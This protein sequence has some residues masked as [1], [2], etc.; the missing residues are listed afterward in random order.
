MEGLLCLSVCL[1]FST[2]SGSLLLLS[3]TLSAFVSFSLR[4]RLV[5]NGSEDDNREHIESHLKVNFSTTLRRCGRNG[6]TIKEETND[7]IMTNVYVSTSHYTLEGE[8]LPNRRRAD[9]ARS[10]FSFLEGIPL[11]IHRRYCQSPQRK[12]VLMN[13]ERKTVNSLSVSLTLSTV[14][15]SCLSLSY[16]YRHKRRDGTTSALW[17]RGEADAKDTDAQSTVQI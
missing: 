12:R 14:C 7:V 6:I 11:T 13:R 16:Q 2:V 10:A 5:T 4:S 1:L 17:Q 15:P 3:L 9:R 8:M